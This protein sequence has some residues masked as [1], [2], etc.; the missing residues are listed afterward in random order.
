VSITFLKMP[1]IELFISCLFNTNE[2]RKEV[3]INFY[4]LT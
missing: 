3:I 2:K 4:N 1:T